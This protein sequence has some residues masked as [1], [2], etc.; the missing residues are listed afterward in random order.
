FDRVILL[1]PA[2]E[3]VLGLS[4]AETLRRAIGEL[5]IDPTLV[6][7]V[8]QCREA[9]HA[10]SRRTIEHTAGERVFAVTLSAIVEQAEGGQPAG[11]RGVVVVLRDVT[12]EREIAKTKSDFVSKVA[13]ELRTPLSSIRAYV[14][15]LVDGEAA[16][17]KTLREYYEIIQSS[18]ER[19]SRLIDNMLNISRIESGTV[20]VAK[21]PVSMAVVVKETIDVVRPQAEAKQI[22][23]RVNLT[24]VFYQVHA[25]KDLL[26][27]A[28]LNLLSNAV[29]Y[30][31]EGGQV[32][33]NMTVREQERTVTTSVTDSG[34]G[35]PE[36]DLP[37]LFE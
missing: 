25:D 26:A 16:D 12:R 33:I 19:L 9:E 30:T 3:G 8:R 35:I 7:H 23:L 27:Q 4:K 5:S 24:P 28:V 18:S 2:A 21:E 1:N 17:E 36:E 11:V 10:V 6:R 13:H 37:R 15:M 14:E 22:E 29:K 31:P 32:T 34:V 20:R